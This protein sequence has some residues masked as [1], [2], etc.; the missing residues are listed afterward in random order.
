MEKEINISEDS[1]I[2]ENELFE[3]FSFKADPGQSPF[4]STSFYLIE[5]KMQQEIKFSKQQK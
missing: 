5:L 2:N 4:E 1:D 3:H